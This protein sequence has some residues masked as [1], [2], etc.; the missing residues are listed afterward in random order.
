MRVVPVLDLLNGVVVRGVAGQ[1][2]SYQPV[3][4]C[5]VNS[6]SPLPVARAFREHF[7]LQT[8]YIADLDAILHGRPNLEIY[9]ELAADGFSL[10]A[11]AGTR[12]VQTART[13]LEFGAQ[14]IIAGL[15]SIPSGRVLQE[16]IAEFG[17][18][19]IIFSL[20]LKRG[21]P[22]SNSPVWHGKGALEIGQQALDCGVRRLIVLDLAQVGI[23]E[24]VSTSPLCSD[25]RQAADKAGISTIEL[26]TGGGIRDI[27]DLHSLALSEIDG[28]L[29]ASALHNGQLNRLD[30]AKFHSKRNAYEIDTVN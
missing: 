21:Q 27:Q 6:C 1:R 14:S 20:D 4:S 28:V 11:D 18:D 15:E 3:Q 8:L 16:L 17:S 23:G 5:L 7:G 25:I 12:D 10:L 24:G 22:L 19:K 2:A 26:I 29:V 30:L 9:R 13:L